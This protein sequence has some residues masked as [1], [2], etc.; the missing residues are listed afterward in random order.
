MRYLI[1]TIT[2]NGLLIDDVVDE[3]EYSFFCLHYGLNPMN[4]GV[5]TNHNVYICEDC[6][7]YHDIKPKCNKCEINN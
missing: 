1:K 2:P 7:R 5:E 6:G 4:A 3:D